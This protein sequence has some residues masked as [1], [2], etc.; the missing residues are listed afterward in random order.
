MC[1]TLIPS[2]INGLVSWTRSAEA[3]AEGWRLRGHLVM[4]ADFGHKD[5]GHK[6][7]NMVDALE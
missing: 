3:E 2:E 5:F 6:I 4:G 1:D 7:V